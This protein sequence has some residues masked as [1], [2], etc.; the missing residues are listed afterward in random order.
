MLLCYHKKE[1]AENLAQNYADVKNQIKLA[2][3]K[4]GR[5]PDEIK[6]VAVSK[7]HPAEVLLEAI[8]AG[9]SVFGENKVQ[10]AEKKIEQIGRGR[11]E[12]H[13]IGHLQ[14]NKAR[15]AVRRFDWI[16][17]IDSVELAERLER[18]CK[19]ENR[20]ELNVLIQVDLAGEAA[21][22]GVPETDLPELVEYLKSREC[23]KLRGFMVLPPFF[24]EAEKTRPFFKRL[25]EIRAALF[26]E[27]EL[28]MGM[29][30][31]FA[32]AIEEGATIVRVGTA[33]FGQREY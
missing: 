11:A 9:A 24:E 33:I 1:M 29:S 32:V 7:T 13:L 5:K 12:W 6:L 14:S 3:E 30:H 19:E 25:C 2:A 26:P 31:D 16:H 15:K 21:K 28:S 8:E 23:L 4:A 27:G 10:E 22:A 18:I 17:T 20:A